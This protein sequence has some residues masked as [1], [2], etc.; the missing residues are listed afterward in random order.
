MIK[1]LGNKETLIGGLY[2][3]KEKIRAETGSLHCTAGY[4]RAFCTEKQYYSL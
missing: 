3:E 4:V 1:S 2:V